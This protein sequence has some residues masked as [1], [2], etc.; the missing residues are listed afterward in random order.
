VNLRVLGG[1]IVALV[2]PSGSGKSTLLR[3][4]L[5]THPPREGT[6]TM[7]GRPVV[8]P[9]RDVG[10]V[11]QRYTLFPFLTALENVALGPMLDRST[12][13]ERAM[14]WKYR[15]AYKGKC[16]EAAQWLE[17]VGLGHCMRAYPAELSGGMCQRVAIAQALVMRPKVLL[18]DEPFGALDEATR[19]ELQTMLLELYQENVAALRDGQ[20]P[21]YTI[22]IVTHE[23]NEALFV[24]DRVM[25]L[26]QYWKWEDE[27]RPSCPGAT[28]IYDAVAPVFAPT[29]PREFDQLREQ[30]TEIR[31]AVMDAEPRRPREAFC[32]FW[33]E[34]DKGLGGGIL[35][36]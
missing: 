6:V 27:G 2:G 26:S 8:R 36:R 4:I 13:L 29:A 22:L 31:R 19:E 32:R 12:L 34:V 23:I 25:G 17:K 18:L 10:I 21:P 28:I 24:S 7:D 1:Q 3:A 30:R 20:E 16:E 5:G 35:Q 9:N 15:G 14:F 33:G 11:Y